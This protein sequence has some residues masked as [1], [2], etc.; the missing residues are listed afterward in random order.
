MM[1]RDDGGKESLRK[2]RLGGMTLP[3]A[4][5]VLLI[6]A[7]LCTCGFAAMGR[8]MVQSSARTI[9]VTFEALV[10]K[11][12]TRAIQTRR[13][14]GLVFEETDRGVEARPYRDGN[15]NG[16]TRA[17]IAAGR[18][19]PLGPAVLLKGEAARIGVPENLTRDPAGAPLGPG[20]AVRFGR[21]DILSFGPTGTAT[22]GSLYVACGPEEAWAFRVCGLNGRVRV[23]WW[24]NG[25]WTLQETR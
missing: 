2:K 3:E 25:L 8:V 15:W 19:T 1:K 6:L 22:P 17:D 7:V 16:I 10:A 24:R 5:V 9:A 12:Q 20:D 18:D 11:V 13:Y 21:G 23:Y 4:L 14:S